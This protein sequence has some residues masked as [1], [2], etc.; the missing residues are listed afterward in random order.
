MIS[1]YYNV[2]L[3]NLKLYKFSKKSDDNDDLYSDASA[4]ASAGSS[5]SV[6]NTKNSH[7]FNTKAT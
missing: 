2:P 4:A 1:K 6:S 5:H 3:Y 7:K